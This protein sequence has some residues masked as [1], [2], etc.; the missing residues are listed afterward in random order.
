M[1]SLSAAAALLLSSLETASRSDGSSFLRLSS[2]APSWG[3]AVVM[4]AHGDEMPN[5]SRYE[6]IRD[7]LSSLS[8]GAYEEEEEA[9][10]DLYEISLSL[11]PVST[12]DI[13]SWFAAHSSRLSSCDDALEA[14]RVSGGSD[15][16]AYELLSEGFRI[17]CEETL[18]SLIS[19]LEE[20]RLSIFNPDTDCQLLLCDSH[21]V[22]IPKLWSWG[23]SNEEEAEDFSVKWEDVLV[24][25]LGPDEEHYWEAWQSICD[26]AEWEESGF[27]WRLLQNGD[28]WA[29]K[30]DCEIPEEWA[31]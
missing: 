31:A 26:S 11:L 1:S 29:V 16:S 4:A 24:C 17:D 7:A 25:Q 5:D 18:S 6:L 20:E 23:I 30:A 14:G 3:S 10:E 27:M 19:S 13:L 15:F 22:Y 2:S 12:C 21:G 8:D 28:L 9:L